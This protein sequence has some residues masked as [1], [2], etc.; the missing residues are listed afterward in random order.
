MVRRPLP[1]AATS[2][3][4]VH[5]GGDSGVGNVS[6]ASAWLVEADGTWGYMV[7]GL[8]GPSATTEHR[9]QLLAIL[10]SVRLG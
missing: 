3:E 10:N 9:G 2:A 7:S 4:S 1:R 6:L 5:I 8:V